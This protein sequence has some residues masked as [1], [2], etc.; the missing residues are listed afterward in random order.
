MEL[1]HIR[2]IGFATGALI[3]G[4]Q[5]VLIARQS[6][7]AQGAERR[8][9]L[10]CG[11]FCL[12]SFFWQFGNLADEAQYTLNADPEHDVLRLTFF[13]RRVALYLIPLSLTYLSPIFEE[14]SGASGWLSGL[15]RWLRALL[16]P[17]SLALIGVQVAW[18]LGWPAHAEWVRF[19]SQT[20]VRLILVFLVLFVVQGFLQLR[21][22]V[23]AGRK[24]AQMANLV[25]LTVCLAG[26]TVLVAADWMNSGSSVRVALMVTLTTI[27]IALSYRQY[28]FPFMDVFILHGT[29][30]ILLLMLLVAGVA[31]GTRWID[32]GVAPL[33]LVAF[34]MALMYVKEPFTRWVERALMGF[35]ESIDAQEDRVGAAIRGLLREDEFAPWVAGE[36]PAVMKA[37]WAC[38]DSER[39]P[40]AALSFEVPGAQTMW[41]SIGERTDGR[42]YMSRQIRLGQ[43]TALQ[44]AAQYERVVREEL[45]RRQ[46]VSQHEMRELTARAQ[47]QALQ[48]QIRPHFLFNTLNVLSNLIHTD[49]RKAEALTEELAAV[50][51][52]TL[53]ATRTEWVS[54][55]DEI[56]FVTSYLRIE[57]A[58]FERRLAYRIDIAP[59]TRRTP[60]P[61]MILQPL[62]ENAVK[63][64]V[65]SRTEG[66]VVV[67]TARSLFRPDASQLELV[68]EDRGKGVKSDE[69]LHGAGIGLKNVRDRLNHVYREKARLDLDK[70]GSEGTRVVLTLPQFMEVR[71]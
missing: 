65:S 45:E 8:G 69:N 10:E 24:Q 46:L 57:Q 9:V 52:Y 32:P 21:S 43:T 50:F 4:L 66:G 37:Q 63:H 14:P 48:A 61:P 31:A 13:I 35:E 6:R 18:F 27:A 70:I 55:E 68:V 41:L 62:V 15:R 59:E 56:R 29:S 1:H 71:A 47:I 7:K 67:V 58:R 2:L 17:W 3:V 19:L 42:T 53:D 25:G 16:W 49:A 26:V 5:T 20:S 64:G 54:L 51:R 44:L 12:V 11:M 28:Q 34:V 39:R 36:L 30:G 22:N 23:A 38:L 33:A 40:A 60:I